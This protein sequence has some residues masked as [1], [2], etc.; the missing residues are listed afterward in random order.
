MR[1]RVSR[2]H[3]HSVNHEPDPE[4]IPILKRA[5]SLVNLNDLVGA[6]HGGRRENAHRLAETVRHEPR[7]LVGD[8]QGAMQLMRAHA[9]LGGRHQVGRLEPLVQRDMTGLENRA[10]FD[11]EVSLALTAAAQANAGALALQLVSAADRAALR[12]DGA[13]R[14]QNAFQLCERCG[15]VGEVGLVEN[16]HGRLPQLPT[17]LYLAAGGVKYIIAQSTVFGA[18]PRPSPGHAGS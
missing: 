18:K 16:A 17:I 10:D 6:A 11:R 14:P 13:V 1:P 4:G 2:V 8:L 5:L 7:A 3:M 12:A 15:F 9:L